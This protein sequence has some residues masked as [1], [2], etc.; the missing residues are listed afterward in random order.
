MRPTS[1]V[2]LMALLWAF[3]V[4]EAAGETGTSDAT[5]PTWLA[6]Y[7]PGPA[8]QEGRP[9]TEQ[10]LGGHFNWLVDRYAEGTMKLAGPFTDDTGGMVILRAADGDAARELLAGDPA[11]ERGIMQYELREVRLHPWGDY[12]EAR[13][14]RRDSPG[15]SS[16]E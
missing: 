13:E 15:G 10:G 14:R 2:V 9:V 4:T 7:H 5:L 8:W 12:V 1:A 6:L 16:P 3:G 11:V